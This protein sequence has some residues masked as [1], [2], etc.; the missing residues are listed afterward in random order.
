MYVH[1]QKI[2]QT[3]G[4]RTHMRAAFILVRMAG[5][6]KMLEH[7]QTST[8]S[9]DDTLHANSQS[10]HARPH[11]GACPNTCGVWHFAA[12]SSLWAN[13]WVVCDKK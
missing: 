13:E 11:M 1:T 2:I 3:L 8:C 4:A 6:A 9:R 10:A 7:G 5:N 12:V